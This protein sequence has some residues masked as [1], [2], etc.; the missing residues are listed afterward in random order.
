M[1]HPQKYV[2]GLLHN[3]YEA[4][5]ELHSPKAK[6]PPAVVDTA[7]YQ[8]PV[9]SCVRPYWDWTM[10]HEDRLTLEE[11]FVWLLEETMPF[12]KTP[13]NHMFCP[14]SLWA[15]QKSETGRPGMES[16]HGFLI[17]RS[18]QNQPILIQVLLTRVLGMAPGKE[19][20][21]RSITT[22]RGQS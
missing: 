12:C 11:H 17:P 19:R 4:G 15:W 5:E 1:G 16:L 18:V 20:T 21:G 22:S 3:A 9:D 10:D 8:F 6:L 7:V 14:T 13:G 2:G